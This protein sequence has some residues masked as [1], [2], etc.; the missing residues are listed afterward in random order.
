[1]IEFI[2]TANIIFTYTKELLQ[3]NKNKNSEK[4]KDFIDLKLKPDL[5][6]QNTLIVENNFE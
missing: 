3:K 6:N 5:K 1:V 4:N 2:R